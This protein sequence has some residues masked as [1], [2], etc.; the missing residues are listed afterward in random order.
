MTTGKDISS[1]A[2]S[3]NVSEHDI[4][5]TLW[6]APLQSA[7]DTPRH[8][9]SGAPSITSLKDILNDHLDIDAYYAE[10]IEDR[11]K[12]LENVHIR[13]EEA[14]QFHANQE[15][16]LFEELERILQDQLFVEMAQERTNEERGSIKA[17]QALLAWEKDQLERALRSLEEELPLQSSVSGSGHP[18]NLSLFDAQ[19]QYRGSVSERAVFIPWL[20]WK[21]A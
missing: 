17:A 1:G 21:R 13:L 18:A 15:R 2:Q 8:A 9:S 16:L 3:L 4:P 20:S 19:V 12:T 14:D 5:N 10:F 6:V 11:P 7:S